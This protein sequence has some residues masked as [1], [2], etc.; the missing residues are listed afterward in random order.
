[1]MSV[2]ERLILLRKTLDI[3]QTDMA[4]VLGCTQANISHY[5]KDGITMSAKCLVLLGDTYNINLNWL[6]LGIGGMF[7]SEGFIP[8]TTE[9]PANKEIVNPKKKTKVI[10]KIDELAV[11]SQRISQELQELKEYL[12]E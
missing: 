8:H 2:G 5:E 10:K 3:N 9:N 1:M 11:E 6:L 7:I 4:M 12:G